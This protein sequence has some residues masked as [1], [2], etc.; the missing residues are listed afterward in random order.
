MNDY[1]IS[2][3]VLVVLAAMGLLGVARGWIT[4]SFSVSVR[5]IPPAKRVPAPEAAETVTAPM[6]LTERTAA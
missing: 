1:A 2:A 4:G 3:A 6:S 5:I